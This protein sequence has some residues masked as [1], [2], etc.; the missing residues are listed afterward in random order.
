MH[1]SRK[2]RSHDLN[3]VMCYFIFTLKKKKSVF[4]KFWAGI[5]ALLLSPETQAPNTMFTILV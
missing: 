4:E 2:K 5:A 3:E 1:I